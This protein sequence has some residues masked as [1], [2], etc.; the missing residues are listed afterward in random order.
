MQNIHTHPE[1]VLILSYM[2]GKRI[3]SSQCYRS[4]KAV[5]FV[6]LARFMKNHNMLQKVC[7]ARC[8]SHKKV[9]L[10]LMPRG[11]HKS[12]R[13]WEI[14]MAMKRYMKAGK[15]IPNEWIAELYDLNS[16]GE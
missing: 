7:V 6:Q 10:G 13:K 5:G 1:L 14:L 3:I 15:R 2:R 12:K 4:M 16:E 11:I 9:P 8:A